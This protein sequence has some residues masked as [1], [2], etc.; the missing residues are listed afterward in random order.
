MNTLTQPFLSLRVPIFSGAVLALAGLLATTVSA[1]ERWE[2]LEA[3]HW[4]ENPH[5]SDRPGRFGELGAYQFREGTWRMHTS[6]PFY[7]ANERKSSD[8][9]AVRHYEWIK[10]GLVRAG[11]EITPYTIALAW[12]GGLTA[13]IRGN[14]TV[15][16]RDY[17]ARVSNMA[18]RLRH[19]QLASTQ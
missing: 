7:R 14:V 9:V 3:I 12:N 11:I 4:V 19:P 15:G 13:A 17:A 10:N 2:T 18:D 6:V 5:N 1:S 8:E 16:T